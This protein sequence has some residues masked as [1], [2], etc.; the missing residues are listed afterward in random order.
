MTG[1]VYSETAN[2]RIQNATV[3][4]C[5][6]GANRMQESIT[7]D[8]GEFA[9]LGLHPGAFILKIS[10]AGYEPAEVRVEVNFATERGLS[11]FLNP[12]RIPLRVLR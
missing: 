3:W 4:L 8:A 6:G 7:T 12:P 1:I 11:V 10:A 5:D 9:F 2:Q